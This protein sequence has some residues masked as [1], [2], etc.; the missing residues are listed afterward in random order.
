[1]LDKD[2]L[3][4]PPTPPEPTQPALHPKEQKRATEA[5][6]ASDA[7]AKVVERSRKAAESSADAAQKLVDGMNRSAAAAENSASASVLTLKLNQR[8]LELSELPRLQ[9][10]TQGFR[11][12]S[13]LVLFRK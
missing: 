9:V 2:Y 10:S 6:A 12:R 5:K 3:I 11:R 13:P 8:A 1:M 4:P 7:Q